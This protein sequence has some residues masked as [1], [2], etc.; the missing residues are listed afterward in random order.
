M[1]ISKAI[2]VYML[3]LQI[4]R[5]SFHLIMIQ[6]CINLL[7]EVYLQIPKRQRIRSHN[8]LH[9][10][11]VEVIRMQNESIRE[12]IPQKPTQGGLPA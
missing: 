4:I 12:Y 7:T 8:S 1:Q 9:L 11:L 6:L 2:Q 3:Q 5:V 10:R